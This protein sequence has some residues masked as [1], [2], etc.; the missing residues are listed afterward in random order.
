MQAVFQGLVEIRQEVL[1][2]FPGAE[3]GAIPLCAL[4]RH[5]VDGI[6]P[7]LL[8]LLQ[9]GA[10]VALI[11]LRVLIRVRV[12]RRVELCR[13][14]LRVQQE[15]AVLGRKQRIQGSV[16]EPDCRFLGAFGVGLDIAILPGV[17][18]LGDGLGCSFR[19]VVVHALCAFI[20]N[21]QKELGLIHILRNGNVIAGARNRQIVLTNNIDVAARIAVGTVCRRN[22]VIDG[23]R[24]VLGGFRAVD[25]DDVLTALDQI[26]VSRYRVLPL[27]RSQ[28]PI[29]GKHNADELRALGAK[30]GKALQV[31]IVDAMPRKRAGEIQ[32]VGRRDTR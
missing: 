26:R 8:L 23:I 14:T 30:H 20:E 12:I 17:K 16:P 9:G 5:F 15:I 11:A 2:P 31:E 29:C 22:A 13:V 32:R 10:G 1:C 25:A 18:P 24:Q 19:V 3:A 27:P 6:P 21:R 4:L 28:I 7:K